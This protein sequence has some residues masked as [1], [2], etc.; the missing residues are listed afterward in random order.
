MVFQA[1]RPLKRSF[2]VPK[3]GYDQRHGDSGGLLRPDEARE[4][5]LPGE[6]GSPHVPSIAELCELNRRIHDDAG[7]PGAFALDQRAPLLGRLEAVSAVDAST[8]EG[9]IEAAA[10][11]AHG[12]AQAQSF[13]DGNRR[14][15]FIATQAFLERHGL[16]YISRGNDDMLT[17]YLNQVVERQAWF[18]LLRPPGP[19]KFQELFARRLAGRT[20]PGAA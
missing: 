13:R 1:E 18:S 9:V 7:F 11:L 19:Q 6:A 2:K 12:I 20:P 8:P 5:A 15:A 17:R 3:R 10:L 4:A 16:A 14:T